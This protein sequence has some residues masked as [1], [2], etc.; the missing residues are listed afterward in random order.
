MTNP[1]DT[2]IMYRQFI[3]DNGEK[4]H[5]PIEFCL[6]IPKESNR[7]ALS[8]KGPPINKFRSS[9]AYIVAIGVLVSVLMGFVAIYLFGSLIDLL[10]IRKEIFTTEDYR[11]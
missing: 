7:I 1:S 2:A 9:L 8:R 5:T 3:C 4:K 6:S 10:G 11:K